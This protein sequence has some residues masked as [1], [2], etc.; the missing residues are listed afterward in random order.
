MP[1]SAGEKWKDMYKK[2]LDFFMIQLPQFDPVEQ[3]L[4][5]SPWHCA[6]LHTVLGLGARL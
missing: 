6:S 1:N 2:T 5:F 4:L 3:Y